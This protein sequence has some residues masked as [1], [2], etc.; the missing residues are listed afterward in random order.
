MQKSQKWVLSFAALAF[1]GLSGCLVVRPYSGPTTADIAHVSV[2]SLNSDFEVYT[3]D[4]AESCSG[5]RHMS[6]FLA[7]SPFSEAIANYANVDAGRPIS[8]GVYLIGP[9]VPVY[10]GI[11]IKRCVPIVN[12]TPQSGRYYRIVVSVDG[13]ICRGALS[14]AD[15][16]QS[17]NFKPEQFRK[18]IFSNGFDETSSFCNAGDLVEPLE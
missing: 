18:M 7:K 3:F 14:S 15:N 13:E 17:A 5:R 12:F 6:E 4:K 8:I 16:A 9:A 2:A 1:G 11:S 10:N